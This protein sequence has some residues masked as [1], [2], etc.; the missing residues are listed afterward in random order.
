MMSALISA[1]CL[2]LVGV[3]CVV[4]VFHPR[5]EDTLG[6]RI[7]MSMVG[8]WCLA[9][10]PTKLWEGAETEPVHLLLHIGLASFALGMAIAK[11]RARHCDCRNEEEARRQAADRGGPLSQH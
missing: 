10:V 11:Y 9:R 1:L 5:Y 6:E 7:G 2:A 3:L 4:G 8:L